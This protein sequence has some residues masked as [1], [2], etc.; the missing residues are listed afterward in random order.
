[1]QI[2]AKIGFARASDT[3]QMHNQGVARVSLKGAFSGQFCLHT[4]PSGRQ[5]LSDVTFSVYTP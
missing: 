2:L 3:R 1:M 4:L 5:R